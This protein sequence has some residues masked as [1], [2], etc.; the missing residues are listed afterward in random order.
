MDKSLPNSQVS[1]FG[2]ANTIFIAY[3][4]AVARGGGGGGGG[5]GGVGGGKGN[6]VNFWRVGAPGL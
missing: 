3:Y 2:K 6:G 5:G 1:G 4:V